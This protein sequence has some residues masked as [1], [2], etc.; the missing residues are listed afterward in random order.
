[1]SKFYERFLVQSYSRFYFSQNRFFTE[2]SVTDGQ[3][4]NHSKDN[5]PS[6][7]RKFY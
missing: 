3:P 5:V 1:M 4:L 2:K 7:S 6:N